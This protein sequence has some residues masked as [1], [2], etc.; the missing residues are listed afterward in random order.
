MDSLK[1][2]LEEAE[3]DEEGWAMTEDDLSKEM[4]FMSSRSMSPKREKP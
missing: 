1:A 3:Q 2:I 4:Q